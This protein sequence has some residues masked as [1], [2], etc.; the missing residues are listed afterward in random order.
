M[1]NR[2]IT[3]KERQAWKFARAAHKGQVRRFINQ[4]YFEAHVKKVNAIFSAVMQN[5]YL[6]LI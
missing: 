1:P 2:P 5:Y 6:K 4:P 3:D